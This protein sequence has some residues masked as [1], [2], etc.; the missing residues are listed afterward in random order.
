MD[1]LDIE[2]VTAYHFTS[3]KKVRG[4]GATPS[5]ALRQPSFIT[6]SKQDDILRFLEIQNLKPDG[7]K[8]PKSTNDVFELTSSKPVPFV[9]QLLS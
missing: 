3:R 8:T 5:E 7:N 2:T 9:K 6:T 1:T 4:G